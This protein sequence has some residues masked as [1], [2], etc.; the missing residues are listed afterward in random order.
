MKKFNMQ[1]VFL[2]IKNDQKGG[3]KFRYSETP[4]LIS[5]Y[6]K[7]QIENSIMHGWDKE[8]IIMIT[9][10][11]FEYMGVSAYVVDEICRWSAFANKMVVINELIKRNIINDN[12]WLHDCDAYQLVPFVFPEECKDVN[13]VRHAPNRDKPQGG[14]V[15][16]RKEAFDIINVLAN[17]IKLFKPTKEES[18]FPNFYHKSCKS[19]AVAKLNSGVEKLS[20]DKIKNQKALDEYIVLRD[21]ASKYFGEFEDR[22][23]WLNW[24]YNLFRQRQFSQKY[25]LADK[26]IKV[27]HF[28]PEDVSCLNCFY[29]GKNSHNVKI[30]NP[31]LSQLFI[32]YGLVK[33]E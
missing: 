23:H 11:P 25:P 28:H 16:Y 18:F 29:Y 2:W 7:L 5:G 15:F 21:F 27:V 26:P 13:F 31:E 14:S 17:A 30:V 6:L 20:I 33:N 4:D 24:T 1:N 3:Y 32:K 22:F 19:K 12:F 10:F 9:N 8:D